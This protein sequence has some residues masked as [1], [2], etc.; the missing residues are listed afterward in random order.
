MVLGEFGVYSLG[1]SP[2]TTVRVTT[3]CSKGDP[4]LNLHGMHCY[5]GG[6]QLASHP[7]NPH[8]SRCVFCRWEK[9]LYLHSTFVGFAGKTAKP[10]WDFK[11]QKR[12]PKKSLFNQDF[13]QLSGSI[14]IGFLRFQLWKQSRKKSH[15]CRS[16]AGRCI[17]DFAAFPVPLCPA[18]CVDAQG[19]IDSSS[20]APEELTARMSGVNV[21]ING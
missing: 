2:W 6:G 7:Y 14:L 1:C 9:P 3:I 18:R 4:E 13:V 21:G 10:S 12:S 16:L 20:R 8:R 11:V 15:G 17:E 19:R 5:F